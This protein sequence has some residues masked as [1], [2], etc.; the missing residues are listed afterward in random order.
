MSY[1]FGAHGAEPA[2][3]KAIRA[4]S[5]FDFNKQTNEVILPDFCP[6]AKLDAVK[7]AI[8]AAYASGIR[9]FRITSLYGLELLR[10]YSDIVRLVS[11]PLPVCNSFA[12][13]ELQ[14]LGADRAMV[15]IE[16]ERPAV[17]A[18][19]S[20]SVLPLELYRLGRPALLTTRAKIPIEG[21]IHDQRGHEFEVRR[22]PLS[23]LT[24]L[25]ARK[26]LSLP[27]LPGIYDYYDL[28]NATWRTADA[29]SFNFDSEWC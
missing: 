23:G 16:L 17:E 12:V 13:L 10:E 3:R 9:R 24:R 25:Y 6:E 8:A 11:T 2:D 1:P 21:A 15:H 18:L 20:K 19:K 14:R 27:R 28:T 5:V 26:V 4:V 22:E 7:R 29:D